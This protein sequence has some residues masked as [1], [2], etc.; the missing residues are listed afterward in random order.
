M[1][2][3]A[4]NWFEEQIKKRK[5]S[6][7]TELENAFVQ[8]AGIV[9][10]QRT[11]EELLDDSIITERAIDEILKYYHLKP[12]EIPEKITETREQLDYCLRH[13]GVMK[14]RVILDEEWYR[15]AYGVLLTK[16]KENG[17]PVVLLPDGFGIHYHFKDRSGNLIKVGRKTA[18]LF[19]KE[20]YCFYKPLPHGKLNAK[21]F[22]LYIKDCMRAKDWLYI[23]VCV[24]IMTAIGL[25]VPQA[26]R[27]LTSDVT[28]SG[29]ISLLLSLGVCLLCTVLSVQ[30]IMTVTGALIRKIKQKTSLTVHSALMMRI[31]NLPSSFFESL[32][33]GELAGCSSAIDELCELLI[34]ATAGTGLT[35]IVSLVYIIQIFHITSP[36][37]FPALMI[38]LITI[39]FG[40]ISAVIHSKVSD[41]QIELGAKEAKTR[42]NVINGIQKIRLSGAEKR[43]F[44]KWLNEYTESRRLTYSPPFM[45]RLNSIITLAISLLS[46]IVLFYHASEHCIGQADYIAFTAAFSAVLGSVRVMTDSFLSVGKINSTLRMLG[47]FL[48][49]EPET[50]G[51]RQVVTEMSGGIELSNVY[52]RYSASSPYILQNISLKIRPKEY[53]AVVGRTGC[54]KST[55]IKILLGL[56]IPERGAVYYDGKDLKSL[57]L[58]TLRSRIGTVMQNGQLFQGD[59]FSNITISAPNA[60]VDDAWAAAETVGIAD[61]I[62]AMP[63]GMNTLVSAGQGGISGGQKQRILIARAIVS[64]PKILIFDEATSALDNISQKQVS[65]ALDKMGCTRIVIAHRLS[66]IRHCDRILVLDNGGIAEDGGYEQLIQKDGIF[67]ELVRRQR[68]DV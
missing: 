22:M 65:D 66:T 18:V 56:R 46:N 21:D 29:S 62:R 34:G 49:A 13:Y 11:A 41:R 37:G 50:T 6:D 25:L 7:Q 3:R 8:A 55:L 58:S 40:L 59:I 2:G 57:D 9:Y 19:E 27:V 15:E 42:Y 48:Q 43:F 4:L 51:N 5:E 36:L 32:N 31:L 33:P 39:V 44:T 23:A 14:R 1:G 67:A 68:S 45:I 60:T 64:K 63:M 47:V 38:L 24:M 53:I 12:V 17:E 28:D 16:D 26:V 54:G 30:F 20:A 61:D 35:A 52:F 10:G